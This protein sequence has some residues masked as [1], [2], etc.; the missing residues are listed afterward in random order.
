MSEGSKKLG[1]YLKSRREASGRSVEEI[2]E[3]LKITTINI[4]N[5]ENGNIESI[6]LS[7]IF[8]R[9]YIK[10]YITELGESPEDIFNKFYEFQN[11]E[12]NKMANDLNAS[13]IFYNPI[14]LVTAVLLFSLVAYFF[15][16][17]AVKKDSGI[18]YLSDVDKVE[19]TNK[20]KIE[21]KGN[22]SKDYDSTYSNY[23]ETTR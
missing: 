16:T 18:M 13:T 19:V 1:K 11:K 6:G 17:Y 23:S 5:I 14:I 22:F 20:S 9:S 2:A 12:N 21:E 4:M 15:I 3:A 10:S 7:E 8:V